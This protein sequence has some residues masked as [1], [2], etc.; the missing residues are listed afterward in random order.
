M[1]AIAVYSVVFMQ[2]DKVVLS[3]ML[4]LDEF[5]RY[6]LATTV[7]S[8]LYTLVNPIFNAVYPRLCSMVV[9]SDAAEVEALYRQTTRLLGAVAFPAAMLLAVA[10]GDLV[11]IWTGDARLG[12]QVAPL[13][14]L[15]AA[16]AALHGVMHAPYALQLAHGR[17]RIPLVINTVLIVVLVP[18]LL[19][20]AARYGAVGG[21]ASWVVLHVLYVVIGAWLTHRELL[22]GLAPR[23]LARDV[24]VPVAISAAA[25]GVALL[26]TRDLSSAW[27]RAATAGALA[28]AATTGI[29]ITSPD[30]RA[31]ALHLLR[32][33]LLTARAGD[34]RP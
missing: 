15:L 27:V 16:G 23:W 29:V 25:A 33:R 1:A 20:L 30:L 24:A 4:P 8:L 2:L 26:L 21:A 9:A 31:N 10:G 18:L 19:A 5:G 3:R 14:A 13:V 28:M 11:A 7:S 34:D 32:T 12:A 17:T 22:R 6:M